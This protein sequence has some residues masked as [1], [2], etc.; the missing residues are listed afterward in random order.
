MSRRITGTPTFVI[1]GETIVGAQPK[2][3]FEKVIEEAAAE[4]EGGSQNSSND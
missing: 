2:E 4:A 3:E 1:N